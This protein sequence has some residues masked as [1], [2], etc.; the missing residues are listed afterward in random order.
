MTQDDFSTN[1]KK[2]TSSVFQAKVSDWLPQVVG[3]NGVYLKIQD[4]DT[5]EIKDIID[6]MTGAAVG[7]LGWGDPA[8]LQIINDAAR[9]TTYSY[10]AVFGN[11]YAEQLADY[12]ISRSPPDAFAAALWTCSGSEA[13]ENALKIIRQYYLERGLTSK[14]KFI[15]RKTSYHG[16]TIGAMSLGSGIRSKMFQEIL[17]PEDQ[18]LKMEPFYPYRNQ[19]EH[20]TLEEYSQRLIQSLEKM[21]IDEG[22]E[23]IAAIIVETLPGSSL[24][25]SPPTSTYLQG[26][27]AICSKYDILFMLDEVMCGTGRCNPNGALNCWENFLQPDQGPDIQTVGKTLG[28]GYVTIAGVLISPKVRK[29]FIN[30]SGNIIGAQTYSSH[31]FNCY[32]A[33]EIQKRIEKLNLTNNIFNVGNYLGEMLKN[34]IKDISIVGDVRGLGG[35]WSI[36]IVKNQ[37]TKEPFSL[38]LKIAPRLQKICFENGVTV[39]GSQGCAAGIGDHVSIAPSFVMTPEIALEVVK[40]VSK[41]LRELNDELKGAEN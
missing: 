40:K 1:I 39:M 27:R 8:A 31:G 13:N 7:A 16:Y 21:V 19:Q 10:P 26:I 2:G 32:V 34:E 3:G 24:G 29:E 36:E 28:S 4:P 38:N 18:C 22:P 9:A 25:T 20:E 15:S 17:L 23:T 5:G 11:K 37:K 30:G 35:F 6:S 14:K 33:L 12:Y 41:S